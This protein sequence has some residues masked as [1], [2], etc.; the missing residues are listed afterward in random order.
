MKRTYIPPRLEE[1]CYMP[2]EGYSVSVGLAQHRDYVI[3]QG[4]DRTDLRAADE[5]TEYTDASG[6][7]YAVGWE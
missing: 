4:T 7:W 3:V 1:Y 2:E 5:V 6:E